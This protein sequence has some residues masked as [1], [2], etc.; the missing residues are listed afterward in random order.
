M[1]YEYS[2]D[3]ENAFS[4]KPEFTININNTELR[5]SNSTSTAEGANVDR[6]DISDEGKAKLRES[7]AEKT[8]AGETEEGQ[9]L[10]AKEKLIKNIQQQI[11]KI[12]EEIEK[13]RQNPE[14]N[15]EMI[16]MLQD[17][18]AQL[19]QQLLKIMKGEER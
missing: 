18:V 12:Q 13:L 3:K 1:S 2:I 16:K 6:V 11:E 4:I 19:Q 8:A 15:K 7:V 5:D 10:S 14:E 17:Q 9:E